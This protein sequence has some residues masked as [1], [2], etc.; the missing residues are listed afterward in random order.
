MILI[1]NRGT[2]LTKV[3]AM[4]ALLVA[5][6]GGCGK[7]H[8]GADA[9]TPWSVQRPRPPLA[10]GGYY[11]YWAVA[12]L[13]T[14]IYIAG[15]DTI[16]KSTNGGTDFSIVNPEPT[17]AGVYDR[18]E[19]VSIAGSGPDDV[20]IAGIPF[21]GI[22][23]DQQGFLIHSADRGESWQPVDLGGLVGPT[24]IWAADRNNLVGVSGLGTVIVT[25]DAGT[26]WRQTFSDPSIALFGVWGAN[27]DDIYAVGGQSPGPA[28]GGAAGDG[29]PGSDDASRSS[30]RSTIVLHSSDGGASWQPALQATSGCALYSVSG[31]ADGSHVYGAGAC[32]TT[33]ESTDQGGTWST[34]SDPGADDSG[35]WVSPS[36]TAHFLRTWQDASS[37][38][39]HGQVFSSS[40]D[41]DLPSW[42]EPG[43]TVMAAPYAIWGTSDDD[44]WV[45][46]GSL[47][48]H[49]R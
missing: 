27:L 21:E 18:P 25:N 1:Q 38:Q 9:G 20:W 11:Q 34:H 26:H 13:G 31:S 49:R 47:V 2:A 15:T 23:G 48:W 37:N 24:N 33:V 36:G 12:G 30:N 42:S 16:M 29:S 32:G 6:A 44:V 43:E 19:Y 14:D 4:L 45:V 5:S 28:D 8:A 10:D 39:I 41:E 22:R 46:G 7:S 35:V 40:L 17:D 3:A